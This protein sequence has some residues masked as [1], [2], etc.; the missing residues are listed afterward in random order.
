MRLRE[1]I[2]LAD[3]RLSRGRFDSLTIAMHWLTVLVVLFLL[4]SGWSFD[5][6]HGTPLRA[7]LV[8]VHRSLGRALWGLTMLRFLWRQSFAPF[9]PFP[10][11]LPGIVRWAAKGSEYALYALLFL[12]P[13]TGLIH[14]LAI[15]HPFALFGVAMGPFNPR[16]PAVNAL[17]DTLHTAGGYGLAALAGS[18]ALAALFHHFLR[19]DDVLKAMLPGRST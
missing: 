5:D 1:A 13:L 9:P 8:M 3:G 15:G 16:W 12:Q 18:H 4:A 7:P 11:D 17:S 6:L 2:T 14:T 10:V 19:R